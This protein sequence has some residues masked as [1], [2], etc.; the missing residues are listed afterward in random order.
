[1]KQELADTNQKLADM[2]TKMDKLTDMIQT[3]IEKK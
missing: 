2:E 1:M 3:L